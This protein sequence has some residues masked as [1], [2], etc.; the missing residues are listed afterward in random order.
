MIIY[1]PIK[2]KNTMKKPVK[3]KHVLTK[4]YP[5]LVIKKAFMIKSCL[6]S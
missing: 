2:H 6:C 5:Y 4:Y 1:N 3:V